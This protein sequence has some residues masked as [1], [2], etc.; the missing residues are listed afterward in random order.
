MPIIEMRT[1]VFFLKKTLPSSGAP[2]GAPRTVKWAA[3]STA[4]VNIGALGVR[5]PENSY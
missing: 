1:V 5:E 2:L 3:W 4:G